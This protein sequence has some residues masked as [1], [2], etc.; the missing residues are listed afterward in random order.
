MWQTWPGIAH[1]LA[2]NEAVVSCAQLL[3]LG[4]PGWGGV[5]DVDSRKSGK[6]AATKL[7]CKET[8]PKIWLDKVNPHLSPL[9]LA[10][11]MCI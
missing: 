1:P 3:T 7:L 11:I 5:G 9:C 4:K 2:A 10:Y 6:D 8:L